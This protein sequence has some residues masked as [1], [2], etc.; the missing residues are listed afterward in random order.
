M[1]TALMSHFARKTA[2]AA[3]VFATVGST[4]F[5]GAAL[6][7]GKGDHKDGK[8]GKKVEVT[9]TGGAGTGGPASGGCVLALNLAVPILNLTPSQTND[10][11]TTSSGVGGAATI[12]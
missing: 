10:C 6:A 11:S 9:I 1:E 2:I 3:V 7:G 8:D 12:D 5:G 4:L